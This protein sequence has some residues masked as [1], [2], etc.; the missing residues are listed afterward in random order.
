MS[1]F[2][3]NFWPTFVAALAVLGIAACLLL[4]WITARKKVPYQ[5]DNTTG[6]VWNVY[7]DHCVLCRLSG[8]LPWFR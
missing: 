8:F 4:L 6:H 2:T 3:S 1:D 7:F 5:S